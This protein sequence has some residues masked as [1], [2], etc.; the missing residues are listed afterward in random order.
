MYVICR[1]KIDKIIRTQASNLACKQP[2]LPVYD[3]EIM[4]FIMEV[5]PID[6]SKAGIDWVKCRVC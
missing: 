3:P 6:C 1:D 5:P 4:R 2:V